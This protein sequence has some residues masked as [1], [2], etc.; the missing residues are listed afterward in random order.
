VYV[1]LLA[2]FLAASGSD[3]SL[4]MRAIALLASPLAAKDALLT[5]YSRE[6]LMSTEA[7][8]SWIAPDIALT[9]GH[10]LIV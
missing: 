3:M 4:E 1:Q 7:R 8:A 6:R 2:Q 5:F 10:F 9:V